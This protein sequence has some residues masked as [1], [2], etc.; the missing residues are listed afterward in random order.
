M[1]SIISPPITKPP[2]L[3]FRLFDFSP[4]ATFQII[5]GTSDV[6]LG[7]GVAAGF[8]FQLRGMHVPFEREHGAA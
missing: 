4:S 8:T 5:T 7:K 1:C 6:P 2:R 3:A